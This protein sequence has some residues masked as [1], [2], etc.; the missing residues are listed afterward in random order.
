LTAH[1][2]KGDREQS[3]RRMDDYLPADRHAELDDI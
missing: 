2:M 3:G 1:A